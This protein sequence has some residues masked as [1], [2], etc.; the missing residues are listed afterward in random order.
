MA[1]WRVSKVFDEESF[2]FN[3][4]T[5]R[6]GYENQFKIFKT[7][8]SFGWDIYA[9]ATFTTPSNKNIRDR[10]NQFVDKLQQIDSHLPLR[11]IPLEIK[12][13]YTN[14]KPI[15]TNKRKIYCVPI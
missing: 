4:C 9:Y 10:M 8:L 5:D 1:L 14:L 6:N 7:Y 13:L 12:N 15:N 2:K 3:T 11:T